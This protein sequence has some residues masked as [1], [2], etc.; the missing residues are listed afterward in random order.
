MSSSS[1]SSGLM[2]REG[3]LADA[4][5]HGRAGCAFSGDV[6]EFFLKVEGGVV[7][8]TG[9]V[10]GPGTYARAS[11]CWLADRIVGCRVDEAAGLSTCAVVRAL[12]LHPI[13]LS[14]AWLAMTALQAALR[15]ISP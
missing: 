13:G 3:V 12:H 6:V 8:D 9:F 15:E 14:G 7:R 1:D 10:A 4:N 2:L 11:A 5:R